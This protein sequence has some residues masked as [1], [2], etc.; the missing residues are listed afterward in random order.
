[1]WGTHLDV[2]KRALL[3]GVHLLEESQVVEADVVAELRL[4]SFH[5]FRRRRQLEH[6]QTLPELLPGQVTVVVPTQRMCTLKMKHV[7][8]V[9]LAIYEILP[10]FAK[11]VFQ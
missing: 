2:H 8:R 10:T 9:Q 6:A 4:E 11:H 7:A 3:G 5:L 1:M